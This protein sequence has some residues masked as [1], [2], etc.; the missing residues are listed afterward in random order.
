MYRYRTKPTHDDQDNENGHVTV[1]STAS[2]ILSVS[3][4]VGPDMADSFLHNL[5]TLSQKNSDPILLIVNSTGGELTDGLAMVDLIQAV[6]A[7]VHSLVTGLCCSAATLFASCCCKRYAFPSSFF[8]IHELAR[9]TLPETKFSEVV[10]DTKVMKDMMHRMLAIYKR[11]TGAPIAQ[12][13]TDL[14]ESKWLTAKGALTYG[15]RG[16]IDQIVTKLPPPWRKLK[17]K[18]KDYL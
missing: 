10:E 8:L 5:L 7:P 2:R 1:I 16:L 12:I 3:G 4:G 17:V 11:S 6:A 9:G 15:K 18:G 13:R 14:K